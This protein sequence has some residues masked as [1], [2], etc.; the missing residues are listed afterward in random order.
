M[1]A[2]VLATRTV[3]MR[4]LAALPLLLVLLSLLLSLCSAV[5][6]GDKSFCPDRNTCCPS[7]DGSTYS[8]SHR[9][10]HALVSTRRLQSRAHPARSQAM[11]ATHAHARSNIHAVAL[12]D[13][14]ALLV[15]SSRNATGCC[16][17]Y[18]ASCCADSHCCPLGYQCS[19]AGGSCVS[20]SRTHRLS[21]TVGNAEYNSEIS[22]DVAN[23]S[24]ND[25]VPLTELRPSKP[26]HAP[27]VALI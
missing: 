23:S 10:W 7:P 3:V 2:A 17:Y 13:L 19:D 24:S 6:C 26:A 16:P 22:E 21:A 18:R 12:L 1:A 15:Y 20:S 8:Q 9:C 11:T 5:Q 14:V 27:T 25:T 4:A